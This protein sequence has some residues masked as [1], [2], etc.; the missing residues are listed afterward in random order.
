MKKNLFF[1]EFNH[2]KNLF[3]DTS[4]KINAEK[5]FKILKILKKIQQHKKRLFIVGLGGSAANCSHAMNDFRKLCK[6]NAICLTDNIS[7][8]TARIN[9]DRDNFYLKEILEVHN[10]KEG[11][12]L[13]LFSVGGG[14]KENNSS[15]SLYELAKFARKKKLIIVSLIGRKK[16]LISAYSNVIINLSLDKNKLI[17]PLAETFQTFIWHYL[18]SS[19]MLKVNKTK[20]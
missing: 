10:P 4:H 18:V 12:C 16:G 3:N 2:F 19:H 13:M 6:I 17:T 7:E 5:I 14:S 9:D 20:W 11:E 1:K 8:L 15:L